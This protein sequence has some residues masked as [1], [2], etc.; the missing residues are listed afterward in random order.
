MKKIVP[1]LLSATVLFS[2]CSKDD[3][4]SASAAISS[5]VDGTTIDFNVN[6]KAVRSQTSGFYSVTIT[7]FQSSSA[8]NQIAIVLTSS[9]PIA[10][11]SYT[12]TDAT[13]QKLSSVNFVQS[14]TPY[15]SYM[16]ATNPSKVTISSITSTAVQGS[17]SGDVFM[18]TTSGISTTKKVITKGQFNLSF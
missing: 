11:G 18:A 5:S 12:E 7:G 3:K 13:G 4:S 15:I 17:F 9:S 2:A 14:G 10:A 1:F 8:S 6:A 16:S